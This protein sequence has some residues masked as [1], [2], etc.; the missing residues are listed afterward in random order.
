MYSQF[1][2]FGL[3]QL[4]VI[5]HDYY[6]KL[7]TSNQLKQYELPAERGTILASSKNGPTPLV[8]NEVRYTV[9]AD[10]KYIKEA[11]KTAVDSAKSNW[12]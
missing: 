3:F 4:Q 11:E 2:L 6:Q 10:P 7:A 9:Y 12:R 1:L 5:K 8:L